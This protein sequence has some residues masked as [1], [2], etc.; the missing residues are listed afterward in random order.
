LAAAHEAGLAHGRVKPSN[1]LLEPADDGTVIDGA[2]NARLTDFGLAA[3]ESWAA[4]HTA[5][6]PAVVAARA[7]YRP[8]E[9]IPGM[10]TT[11]AGDVYAA[12]VLLYEA[13]TG[14]SLADNANPSRPHDAS[15]AAAAT[16]TDAFRTL[17]AQCLEGRPRLRP[18]AAQ[19]A[20]RLRGTTPGPRLSI[21][22]AGS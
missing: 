4:H 19:M 12:G 14:N 6:D 17:L 18:T 9:W 8:P 5:P 1:V 16:A 13:L 3:L 10:P 20:H 11:S 22:H 15:A 2:V 7:L 21:P